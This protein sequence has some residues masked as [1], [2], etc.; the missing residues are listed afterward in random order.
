MKEK[1]FTKITEEV[2][3]IY[4]LSRFLF[5]FWLF[6]TFAYSLIQFIYNDSYGF[7]VLGEYWPLTLEGYSRKL[8]VIVIN[9]FTLMSKSLPI[10][11]I[12]FYTGISLKASRALSSSSIKSLFV[13]WFVQAFNFV[14]IIPSDSGLFSYNVFDINNN[15]S[16][17]SI[18]IMSLIAIPAILSRIRKSQAQNTE[19][20]DSIYSIFKTNLQKVPHNL[21][22]SCIA[23]IVALLFDLNLQ[24]KNLVISNGILFGV[25]LS[26]LLLPKDSIQQIILYLLAP[27]T[28]LYAYQELKAIQQLKLRKAKSE[29]IG[30]LSDIDV[31][32]A[33]IDSEIV[34]NESANKIYQTLSKAS[35]KYAEVKSLNLEERINDL[36]VQLEKEEIDLN[37]Y[38]EIMQNIFKELQDTYKNIK[39]KQLLILHQSEGD[40]D[41]D[42][43]ENKNK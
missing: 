38:S 13:F 35:K 17:I 24:L 23:I 32:E 25:A 28:S 4:R 36:T 1:N 22:I 43:E 20:E 19:A 26:L 41:A 42:N 34:K 33:L 7:R 6:T 37:Q 2:I 29:M 30:K 9:S 11:F 39:N 21:Y 31:Q 40:T 18:V 3:S 5:L 12:F 15:E 14:F 10:F 16:I 27:D 8:Y